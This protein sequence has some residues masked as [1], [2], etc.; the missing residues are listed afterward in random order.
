MS[1]PDPTGNDESGKKEAPL[2]TVG[3]GKITVFNYPIEANIFA[4]ACYLPIPP[5]NIIPC[6]IALN[7]PADNPNFIRFNAVQSLIFSGGFFAITTILGALMG[8]LGVIP[9]I[10]P[11]LNMVL[12][13]AQFL[14]IAVYVLASLKL[15]VGAYLGQTWEMPLIGPYARKYSKT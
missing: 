8:V 4:A 2:N 11:L 10:G 13:L 7:T 12:G 14:I 3:L 9:L 5:A 6:F 15:V 1:L